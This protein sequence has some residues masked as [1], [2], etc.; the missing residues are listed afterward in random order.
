[1]DSVS[2]QNEFKLSYTCQLRDATP[3]VD[4]YYAIVGGEFVS[5]QEWKVRN[6][7]G[8][9]YAHFD[10][11]VSLDRV[12]KYISN[13]RTVARHGFYP[14]IH[15]TLSFHKYNKAIGEKKDKKREICYSAHL[16]RYMYQYYAFKL[17]QYYNRRVNIDGLDDVAIAYRD[18]LHKNN[19]HFAKRAIDFIKANPECHVIIGDFTGFFDN[20][21]HDY[22]KD[23]ICNLLNVDRLPDDYYAVYK[24]ITRYSCW[25]LEDLL[26]FNGL[27]NNPRGVQAFKQLDRA[28]SPSDFRIHKKKLVKPHKETFGIPQGSAISAVLSNIYM[29]ELDR[30]INQHVAER[31]GLYMRYSDDFIVIFPGSNLD[32]FKT[33][34]SF[35]TSVIKS[36]PRLEL[37]PDKTQFFKYTHGVLSNCNEEIL[38]NVQK[39]K[40]MLNYL[41]FSFD[42]KKVRLRDKTI[43][44]YYYRL[45]RK[46]KTIVK[47]KGVTKHGKRISCANVYEKYSIKGANESDRGNFISYV[48]RAEKVFAGE[49]A[50]G[51]IRRRHMRQIRKRLNQIEK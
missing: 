46:L 51:N 49:D 17:N 39:G 12:W 50:I 18:N 10:S 32:E 35:I 29:L 34:F 22:L 43:S 28:I 42:G 31:Q 11:R 9:N 27:P 1:M 8:R 33:D 13:P 38:P 15:Y 14:F 41:G 6:K 37:E 45:Y 26:Q 7:F 23:T 3:H 20:L 21:D 48:Q 16:D 19:I 25:N 30:K 47:R 40:N 5:L 44:K 36:I 2:Q 4:G 24:N